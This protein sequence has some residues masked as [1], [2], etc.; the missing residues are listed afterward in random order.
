MGG[1]VTGLHV[2]QNDVGPESLS[3]LDT[4]YSI[5]QAVVNAL[6]SYSNY[7]VDSGAANAMVVT[8][9]AGQTVNLVDG[10]LIQVTAA[11]SNTINNPSLNLNG[12]GAKTIVDAVGGVLAPGQIFAGGRHQFLYDGVNWRLLNYETF[13]GTTFAQTVAGSPA[14]IINSLSTSGQS[15]GLTCNGGT[16][17]AD[18][19]AIFR[20]QAGLNMFEI[21][22]SGRVLMWDAPGGNV[23]QVGWMDLPVVSFA[24]NYST[25]L[26]DRGKMILHNSAS[27]HTV[28]INDVTVGGYPTGT[29]LTIMN[30]TGNGVVT[31][32]LQTTPTNLRWSPSGAT[33]NRTLAADGIATCVKISGVGP[34]GVFEISGTGIT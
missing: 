3:L 30:P 8:L 18:W 32:S 14:I 17:A 29:V 26:T 11:A 28:T 4:N 27:A 23:N 24:A 10:L 5:I 20:N 1:V 12:L 22:G 31:I 6:N 7:Y 19:S 16:T 15:F 33:G 9:A 34:P 2:F 25:V 21:D 13:N